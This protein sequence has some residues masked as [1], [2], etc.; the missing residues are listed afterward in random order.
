MAK[1]QLLKDDLKSSDLGKRLRDWEKKHPHPDPF[2]DPKYNANFRHWLQMPVW[3]AHEA[4]TLSLGK[5]P[6]CMSSNQ[7][8]QMVC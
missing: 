8:G 2:D 1:K 5:D 6:R 4:I 7:I 3:T